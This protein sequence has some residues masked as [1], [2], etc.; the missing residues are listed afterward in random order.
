MIMVS[1]WGMII[2]SHWGMIMVS[3]MVDIGSQNT[4]GTCKLFSFDMLRFFTI[5]NLISKTVRTVTIKG[6]CR[7]TLN[8]FL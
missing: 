1:H 5:V 2:V 8:T 6:P 3:L 4:Y 7:Q